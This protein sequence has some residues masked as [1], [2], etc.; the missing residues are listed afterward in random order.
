M[1][2]PDPTSPA[3]YN[4]KRRALVSTEHHDA[5]THIV[6]GD[7]KFGLTFAKLF[8]KPSILDSDHRLIGEGRRR[9]RFLC[10]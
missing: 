6:E 4:S 2:P 5:I 7:P 9:A 8:E 10:S 3:G 1:G